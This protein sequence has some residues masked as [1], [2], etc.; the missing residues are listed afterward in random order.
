MNPLISIIIPVKNE[1][2]TLKKCL[3]SLKKLNY[4]NYEIIVV[5]DNSSDGTL[6]ILNSYPKIQ[7]IKTPGIGISGCK[8]LGSKQAKGAYIVF[9]DADCIFHSEWLNELYKG[10]ESVEIVG[11]GGDQLSP[12]DETEFGKMVQRFLKEVVSFV[13]D[14]VK[15]EGYTSPALSQNGIKLIPTN[16]NSNCNAMYKKE[17]FDKVGGFLEELRCGEDV[18]LDYRIKKIGKLMYNPKAI[19]YHYRPDK[20]WKF[21]QKMERYG[22]AQGLLV[23]KHGVFRLIHYEPI[24]LFILFSSIICFLVYNLRLGISLLF[25]SV[26]PVIYLFIK[27]KSIG[28]GY[29]WTTPK[30]GF[31][32][33]FGYNFS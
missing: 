23:K 3:D 16:H 21:C 8:N 13:G 19:V 5:D 11:V 25:C 20:L 32:L 17:A 1:Q 2:K 14:Y 15:K 18:E 29:F 27:T 7:I 4:D 33:P 22:F 31:H 12:E 30:I 10:F 26:I 9:T 28:C 6:Q 24:F